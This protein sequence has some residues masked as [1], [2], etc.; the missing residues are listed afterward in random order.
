MARAGGEGSLKES[1]QV[2]PLGL[3][4]RNVSLNTCMQW[5]Y[6]VKEYQVSGVSWTGSERYD[7]FAKT[8]SPV[9]E[10]RLRLMLRT[11]LAD[12][13]RLEFHHDRKEIAVDALLPGRVSPRLKETREDT[14]NSINLI[15]PG[16]RLAFRHESMSQTGGHALDPDRDRPAGARSDRDRRVRRFTLDS[17]ELR[18]EDAAEPG[19]S[20]S[21]VISEQ[22][23]L[24][25]EARRAPLDV[26][27]IER[28]ERVPIA[29]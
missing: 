3:T 20:A 26:L 16:S 23:G 14:P 2:S 7:V 6:G 27:V 19:P 12:R 17:R 5:A 13:F 29:N 11:L 25:L 1:I 21:S 28:A 24:R 22:L 10:D 9:G 18:P 15:R 8:G 4:M